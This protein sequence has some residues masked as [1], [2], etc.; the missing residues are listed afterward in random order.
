MIIKK[1]KQINFFYFI[2][3]L[4]IVFLVYKLTSSSETK[5]NL[6]QYI[7]EPCRICGAGNS[8]L[9]AYVFIS[10]SN[11][12]KRAVIRETWGK[13]QFSNDIKVVFML[14]LS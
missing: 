10:V 7:T 1:I 8:T 14:G 3:T 11:F 12:E 6:F 13:V 5:Q 4:T 2:S 9:F